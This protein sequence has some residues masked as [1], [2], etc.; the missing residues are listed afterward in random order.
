M[1]LMQNILY[2]SHFKNNTSIAIIIVY[3]GKF[4]HNRNFR[5]RLQTFSI[6]KSYGVRCV[7]NVIEMALLARSEI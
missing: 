2:S 1:I 6:L 3:I 5:L 4:V 7:Y